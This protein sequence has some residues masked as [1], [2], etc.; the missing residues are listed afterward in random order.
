VFS[1]RHD[2]FMEVSPELCVSFPPL[3]I[4]PTFDTI[5]RKMFRD[6]VLGF[7][8]HY[9]TNE[10]TLMGAGDI[11]L[12]HTDGLT[13]H[14][15]GDVNYF[16]DRLE[17]VLRRVKHQPAREIHDAILADLLSFAAPADDVSFVVVKKLM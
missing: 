10:W 17:Q 1:N 5:D 15:S 9:E 8:D 2:R 11:L 4:Q 16:P 14:A 12:L 3:G 13:E 6:S 7:K